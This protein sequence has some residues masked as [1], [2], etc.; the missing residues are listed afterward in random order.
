ML[1]R[2]WFKPARGQFQTY[3]RAGGDQQEYRPDFVAETT[4]AILMLEPKARGEIGSAEVQAKKMAA[5]EWCRNASAYAATYGGR[6]W[7]YALIPHDIIAE[8]MTLK[9]LLRGNQPA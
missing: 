9:G 2:R 7:M 6:A 4:D 5:E 8:N 1:H 3:Y